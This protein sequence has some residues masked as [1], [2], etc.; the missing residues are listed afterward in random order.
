M[1]GDNENNNKK[2]QD[3]RKEREQR[4]RELSNKT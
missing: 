2:R 4:G 3:G 1:D